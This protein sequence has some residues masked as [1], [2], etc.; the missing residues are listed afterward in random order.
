MKKAP[1]KAPKQTPRQA[2]VL[3]GGKGTRL[4][5]LTRETPK[6][7]IPVGGKPFIDY[8]LWNLERHGIRDIILSVGYLHEQFGPVA[9]Q[10]G[11]ARVRTV[12]ETEP[13][14]TGGALRHC[15]PQLDESFLVL[16]AD[17]MFD[18]NLLDLPLL[19][20]GDVRAAMALRRVDDTARYGAVELAGERVAAF[21]EKGVVPGAAYDG[22]E[23]GGVINGGVYALR[24]EVVEALPAGRALSLESEVFPALVEQGTLAA[25]EYQGFF[26]DIGIPQDLERAQRAVPDWQR[27]RAVF[28][29]RDGVLNVDHGYVH[30]PEGFAWVEGAPEA[31]KWINDQ[32]MLAIVITN[33][34][35]IG[36]GYYTE[37]DFLA[38]MEWMGQELLPFGA[39]FDDVFYCP[40]HLDAKLPEFRRACPCRKPEPGMVLKAAER[41][42][43]DLA[44]SVF[45]GDKQSDLD[46]GRAAGVPE[47]HLFSGGNLLEFVR[48]RL[49]AS[50]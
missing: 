43:L 27:K 31:V 19:L 12:R 44:G 36:R 37:A 49:A 35:G 40:H 46:A 16:N 17:T 4:G 32:G 39:H 25:R 24:R 38:F 26:I 15:L 42:G 3:A 34:S 18:M 30:S 23:N 6:P 1:K 22:G 50:E 11:R 33:Q 14:G 47:G 9:G 48:S 10:W 20:R 21:R 29:D 8:L 28:L 7:M 5:A 2:I 45:I 13:L 41:W